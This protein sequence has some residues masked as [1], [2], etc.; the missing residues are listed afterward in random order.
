MIRDVGNIELC[1]LLETEN[2]TQC[3]V[4][5]SLWNIGFLYCTCG[6][7]LHK[8]RGANQ[9]FINYTMDLLPVPEYAIKKGRPHGYRYGKKPGDREYSTANQL[10][11][12]CKKKYF[13]GIHDRFIRDREFRNRMIENHRDE[14][15]CR[16]KDALTDED[17]THHL[18]SQ[19]YSLC[20][21]KWWLHSNK[22]G[23]NS[24]PATHRP[25]FKQALSTLQ[26]LKQETEGDSQVPTYSNR[27][28]QWAQSSS[29]TWWN[30]QGSWWTP[31]PCES[32]DGDAPSTD[33]T[34]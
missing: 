16:R 34:G 29:S 13:Q 7:F 8:E 5:L 23:S 18:T 15:L 27:N 12:R 19:E 17:D 14:E 20:K 21:S 11:K 24:M 28:Q 9:Q 33:R 4:C 6:H 32:H 22:Q 25:D 1:E 3:T 2:Q 30:W 31:Y 10:K 26:R